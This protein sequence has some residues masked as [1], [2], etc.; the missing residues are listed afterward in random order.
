VFDNVDV[1]ALLAQVTGVRPEKTDG[2]LKVVRKAL[3]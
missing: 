2:S 1:Y 3:R